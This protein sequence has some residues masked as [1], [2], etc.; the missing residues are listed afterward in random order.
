M[1]GRPWLAELKSPREK[2]WQGDDL[3]IHTLGLVLKL[4]AA[5]LREATFT[6]RGHDLVPGLDSQEDAALCHRIFLEQNQL[7]MCCLVLGWKEE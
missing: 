2:S 6:S 5:F 4:Q 1:T 7:C 3:H